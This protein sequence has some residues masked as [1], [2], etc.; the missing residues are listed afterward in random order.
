MELMKG[1]QENAV[2]DMGDADGESWPE[3][4]EPSWDMEDAETEGEMS[5]RIHVEYTNGTV[6]DMACYDGGLM[7]KPEELYYSLLEYFEPE[8]DMIYY[9]KDYYAVPDTGAE[10]AYEL[11]RQSMLSLK[12]VAVAKTVMGTN[13]KLL[14]LYPTKEGIIVK[15]LFFHDEIAAVPKPL[16][17][18]KLD[19]NELSMAKML[20]ENMAKPFVAENFHDEY[21]ERL[22]AAIIK[23]I[24]GQEIVSADTGGTANVIDLMDAL[25]KSLE[26]SAKKDKGSRERLT[27]TA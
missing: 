2:S 16:R 22:R 7:D 13:E 18:M 1:N 15:T 8:V 20:V 17:K 19:G 6:Q 12:K 14:V 27:G 9:E 11:L 25:Q 4:W 26:L 21:Q 5:W 10:K 24:E 3:E 23:K